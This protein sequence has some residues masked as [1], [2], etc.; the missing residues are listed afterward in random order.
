MPRI[1]TIKPQFWL[2][3][4]LG[5]ICRDARLLYIGLWNLA[6]DQGVFEY[7]PARIKAQLFPY[8][9]DISGDNIGQWLQILENTGDIV[10]F[11]SNGSSFGYIPTFLKHQH[12]ENPSKWRCAEIPPE[13]QQTN[14][15]ALTEDSPP[16]PQA[17]TED[18]PPSPQALSLGNREKERGIG[19][20]ESKKA[21]NKLSSPLGIKTKEIFARI[22]KIRGYRPPKR[23]AEASSILR[24]LKKD[25]TPD[26]II[27]TWQEL[28]Q[29]KF[30]VDK[31]L[32]MMTVEGQIGAMLK[33]KQ[34]ITTQSDKPS[35]F[36]GM[37]K[38]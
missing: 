21:N 30:W 34:G 9:S 33:H 1:R 25:Y 29:D 11:S 23:N 2:D 36:Q 6:D 24:M 4:H 13:F 7:R 31:E 14:H 35:K 15:Q 10:R 26:Q 37:V 5:S 17:L 28:K 18:S 22:D 16:S 19:N 12:I 8:D 3:E 32:V 20:K 38:S 27:E